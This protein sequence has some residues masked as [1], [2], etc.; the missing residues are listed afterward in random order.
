MTTDT[1]VKFE[2]LSRQGTGPMGG[3]WFSRC[4]LWLAQDH[5]LS[6]HNTGYS[7]DYKRFYFADIQAITIMRT[8]EGA[9]RTW[10]FSA[11]AVIA[12]LLLV[13]AFAA[14]W[15]PSSRL[16]LGVSAILFLTGLLI[17]LLQGQTCRCYMR[18]AVQTERLYSLNR[19][20][21]A[22]RVLKRLLPL[23]ENAQ[24]RVAPEEIEAA[25]FRARIAE[26]DE[27][28]AP[29][30]PQP[31]PALT[32][33][34]TTPK[35]FRQ[36][37]LKPYRG[38]AHTLLFGL[39]GADLLLEAAHY[40][41]SGSSLLIAVLAVSIALLVA[42]IVAL[43]RQHGTTLPLGVKVVSWISL[44]YVFLC[45]IIGSIYS[46]IYMIMH[47]DLANDAWGCARAIAAISP[48]DSIPRLI[49]SIFTMVGSGTLALTGLIL[50][51]RRPMGHP[52]L[53]PPLTPQTD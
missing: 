24:G 52:R 3:L 36:K 35:V 47:P 19:L 49:L 21:Q 1:P 43:I 5:L 30:A 12:G 34:R 31:A 32:A 27:A 14:G 16:V 50:L 8:D 10:L 44:G 25:Q 51:A 26:E 29:A 18:T 6:V 39:L 2:K 40:L 13:A 53:P 17:H 9:T 33:R 20:P 22:E 46:T 42:T 23:V 48:L 11:G 4:R 41:V 7:E 37:I 15:H 38:S 45:Y 28:G